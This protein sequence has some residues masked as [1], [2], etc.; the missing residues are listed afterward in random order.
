MRRRQCRSMGI[1]RRILLVPARFGGGRLTERVGGGNGS[2][3]PKLAV[4]KTRRDW[5]NWVV[6]GHSSIPW[7]TPR[8]E[9]SHSAAWKFFEGDL[10]RLENRHKLVSPTAIPP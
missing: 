2:K 4:R 7:R 1:Y 8:S 9:R 6:C 5:L 3:C 10:L